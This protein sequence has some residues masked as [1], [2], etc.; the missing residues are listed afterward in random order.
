MD[1]EGSTQV[2]L[3]DLLGE[4]LAVVFVGANPSIF[5]AER[6]HYYARPSNRF[7]PALS[8][9]GLSAEA[10]RGL[11]VDRLRPEHDR[12]LLQYGFGFT[13]VVKRPTRGI[14]DVARQEWED[15]ARDLAAKLLLHVPRIAC[16]QD[17]RGCTTFLRGACAVTDAIALGLQPVRLGVTQLFLLPSPSGANAHSSRA[18]QTAWYDTLHAH[19]TGS[20]GQ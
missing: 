2:T 3:P 18:A 14:A 19:L 6:G 11:G 8:A 20:A 7:W 10:R 5:S 15:G 13:D 17:R 16:F 1:A 9:S 12:A 4:G